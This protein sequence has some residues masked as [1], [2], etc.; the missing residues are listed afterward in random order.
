[1]QNSNKILLGVVA[2]GAGLYFYRLRTAAKNLIFKAEAV[3]IQKVE[4]LYTTLKIDYSVINPAGQSISIKSFA[5]TI[6]FN[7]SDIGT[8][9][10]LTKFSIPGAGT[11]KGSFEIRISNLGAAKQ[12]IAFKTL[13]QKKEINISGVIFTPFGNSDF[14]QNI[15]L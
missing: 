8:F 1:M 3:N 2:A 7:G 12:L 15:S 5:G 9:N 14:S 6:S 13:G 4:L 10:N 11:F